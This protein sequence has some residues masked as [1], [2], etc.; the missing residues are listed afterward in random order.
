MRVKR[1]RISSQR[2]PPWKGSQQLHPGT[3]SKGNFIPSPSNSGR[4]N[5]TTVKLE[6]TSTSSFQSSRLPQIRGK[7]QKS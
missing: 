4:M 5:G 6:E 2:N 7:D 3:S 1:Q